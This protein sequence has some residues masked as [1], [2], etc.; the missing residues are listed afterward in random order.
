MDQ[1]FLSDSE[2]YYSTSIS[3]NKIILEDS[4]AS[5]AGRVMRHSIGDRLF[6]TDGKG[7]IY[8]AEISTVSKRS[9][10]LQILSTRTYKNRLNN[11]K[12]C[13][14]RIKVQDRLEFAIEKV[15]ELGF[16]NILIYE[17]ERAIGKKDKTDRWEKIGIA[18]MKQS[19]RSYL[20]KISYSKNIFDDTEKAATLFFDQNAERNIKDFL[21]NKRTEDDVNYRMIIGPEGGFT[22]REYRL[23]EKYIKLKLSNYR[24]RS[25]T[26]VVTAASIISQELL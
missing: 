25:E 10:E 24:L 15:V 21:Q 4:E 1:G 12:I 9:I 19:L 26:A 11:V 13:I 8:E 22:E 14:P 2:L 5:H 16:T 3:D 18:A 23:S 20:P 7:S 17:S 6:V